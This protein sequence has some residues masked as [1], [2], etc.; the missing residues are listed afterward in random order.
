MERAR[1]VRG[2]EVAL[3]LVIPFVV[4]VAGVVGTRVL[5]QNARGDLDTGDR[6]FLLLLTLLLPFACYAA[7]A[8][9]AGSGPAICTA[10]GANSP[11]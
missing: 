11:A 1:V 9:I 4:G 6:A 7:S 10:M 2:G 3:A 5:T 8:L